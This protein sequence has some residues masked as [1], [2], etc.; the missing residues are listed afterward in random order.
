MEKGQADVM[1]SLTHLQSDKVAQKLL[2][3]QV[4][5]VRDKSDPTNCNHG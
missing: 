2:S 5:K 1:S 3:N 4:E